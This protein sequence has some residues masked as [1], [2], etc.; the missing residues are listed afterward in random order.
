MPLGVL[1]SLHIP[2]AMIAFGAALQ[3]V[4]IPKRHVFAV[5]TVLAA[6]LIPG[7]VIAVLALGFSPD[8]LTY[9][10]RSAAMAVCLLAPIS[11]EVRSALSCPVAMDSQA[12]CVC[13]AY[14]LGCP[15]D[16]GAYDCCVG[17]RILARPA[18]IH[19]ALFGNGGL[20]A[21]TGFV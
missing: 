14:C 11:F 20:L 9:T 4:T 8:Q 3:R 7:L 1:A 15:P 12:A 19:N 13:C 16:S 21:G 17:A 10:M 18:D 2:L 6:R 5:R